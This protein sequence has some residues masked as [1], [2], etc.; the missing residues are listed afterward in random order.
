MA[1]EYDINVTKCKYEPAFHGVLVQGHLLR[2]GTHAPA[3]VKGVLVTAR[4]G[5][6]EAFGNGNTNE[7]GWFSAVITTDEPSSRDGEVWVFGAEAFP[8]K[9]FVSH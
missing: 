5:W 8:T 4:A 7:A 6:T 1:N 9:T 2:T 3:L